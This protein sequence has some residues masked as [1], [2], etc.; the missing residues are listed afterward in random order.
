MQAKTA[1]W[2]V[3]KI[4]LRSYEL[5]TSSTPSVSIGSSAHRADS[6]VSGLFES[7]TDGMPS[8][9]DH[10]YRVQTPMPHEKW[11]NEHYLVRKWSWWTTCVVINLNGYGL[12]CR[13]SSLQLSPYNFLT[14]IWLSNSKRPLYTCKLK[15]VKHLNAC[16]GKQPKTR[17]TSFEIMMIY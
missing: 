16:C 14:T 15:Q 9:R 12:N 7:A 2:A 4:L 6:K 3:Y 11:G 1:Q 17:A 13:I 5:K 10:F 8:K